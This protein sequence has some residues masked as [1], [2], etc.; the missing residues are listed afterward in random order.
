MDAI[1]YTSNT[2]STE[3]Y[4]KLLSETIGVPAY[5]LKKANDL[6]PNA[7]I[8]YLGWV[9]GGNIS[10]YKK[11]KGK[12]HIKAVCAVGMTSPTEEAAEEIAKNNEA[13]GTKLFV[14][15]GGFDLNKLHGIKKVMMKMMTPN[16]IAQLEAKPE[17]TDGEKDTLLLLKNGG[18]RV[19]PEAL[20]D[21]IAWYSNAE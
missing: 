4:A 17:L 18:S 13:D 1:L 8:I 19:K 15:Q 21:V 7:E 2:G 9:F 14:L 11:A 10:G 3:Q 5:S 6:R 16:L 20:S 12:Y